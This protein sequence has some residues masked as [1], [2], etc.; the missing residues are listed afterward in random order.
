MLGVG[1]FNRT[2]IF[3]FQNTQEFQNEVYVENC[4]LEK[5]LSF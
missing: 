4:A 3:F 1:T 2:S 5:N